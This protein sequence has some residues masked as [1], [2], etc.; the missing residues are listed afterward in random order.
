MEEKKEIYK[1]EIP[2]IKV[3]LYTS[4]T[5]K[6][7]EH[8]I[9]L[10][11]I[12]DR[13]PKYIS[14]GYSCNSDLWDNK[15]NCPVKNHPNKLL[16]DTVITQKINEAQR[17]LLE[18]DAE[19]KS[20]SLDELKKKYVGNRESITVLKYHDLLIS[21]FKKANQLG[22]A[23]VYTDSKRAL[24]KFNKDSDFNFSDVTYSFLKKYEQSFKETGAKDTS[25][26]FYMRTLRAVF[27]RA[28]KE[29][30]CKSGLY[31]FNDYKISELKTETK[32]RALSKDIIHEIIS[33]KLTDESLIHARNYFLFSYY[34]MGLNFTD[35]ARLKWSN[36]ENDRLQYTRTKTGKL[37]SIALL[38]PAKKILSLYKTKY[39]N[40][41]SD[42]I[43]PILKENHKTE[44]SKRNR[45]HKIISLVNKDLKQIAIKAGAT[46]NLTTYVS[47]HSWATIMKKS[48]VSTSI[49]S[50][51]MG[52]STEKTTQV[53]LDSF[54]MD[55]LDEANKKL[56]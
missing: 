13:K 39:I 55:V 9:M 38:E 27:N 49:I 37:Y 33:L 19:K 30:I 28:I 44:I 8:P 6:N 43:F 47:R 34:T 16:L 20:Y 41:D 12:K 48:G 50:A 4:K 2:S 18:F 1:R 25:I 42:Y 10:R 14:I 46:V 45:I 11:F 53:Y 7:G 35:L 23:T 52:H 31:P 40:I 51:G 24:Q 32:K 3:T 56:L 21:G 5:L 26:S 22:N 15:N 17:L 54:E 36:I 29:G